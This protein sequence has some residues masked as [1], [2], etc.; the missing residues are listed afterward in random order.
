MSRDRPSFWWLKRLGAAYLVLVITFAIVYWAWT[1]HSYARLAAIIDQVHARGEPVLP[2]EFDPPPIADSDDAAIVLR[3]AARLFKPDERWDGQLSSEGRHRYPLPRPTTPADFALVRGVADRHAKALGLIRRATTLPAAD[4]GIRLRTQLISLK[5]PDLNNQRHLVNFTS[6]LALTRHVDG[7]D[8]A[9]LELCHDTLRL[10]HHV[11]DNS[12]FDVCQL[13]GWGMMGSAYAAIEAIAPEANLQSSGAEQAARTLLAELL[14]ERRLRANWLR[15][16]QAQRAFVR[17]ILISYLEPKAKLALPMHRIDTAREMTARGVVIEAAHCASYADAQ[18]LLLPRQPPWQLAEFR[19]L[20]GWRRSF[21][22]VYPPRLYRQTRLITYLYQDP[23]RS[24]KA[25]FGNLANRRAAAALL[26]LRLY[27]LD[28]HEQLPT[29]WEDL[30]SAY[31]PNAPADPFA[32]AGAPMRLLIR[33]RDFAF[34]SLGPNGVDDGA[35]EIDKRG[36]ASL[37]RVQTIDSVY[38][39]TPSRSTTSAP[40]SAR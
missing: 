4:W 35:A 24:A 15:S 30:V 23:T 27:Q 36:R 26:A 19:D 5:L 8:A 25:F 10:G 14:D 12:P 34:Y 31:L 16:C 33:D 39:F 20:S 2:E 3:E 17:D 18:P 32:P 6:A 11:C 29:R 13:A 37:D 7:D 38:H 21:Q 28:H 9:A 40:A 1:R 22:P